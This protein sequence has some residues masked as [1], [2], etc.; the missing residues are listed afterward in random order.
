[1]AQRGLV[2]CPRPHSPSLAEL[3]FGSSFILSILNNEEL[4]SGQQ[5]QR[6]DT[7]HELAEEMAGPR[8]C[9]GTGWPGLRSNSSRNVMNHRAQATSSLAVVVTD[10]F[11]LHPV[12]EV[13]GLGIGPCSRASGNPALSPDLLGSSTLLGLRLWS[14][15]HVAFCKLS[16]WTSLVP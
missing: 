1:M 9:S 13:K 7:E 12:P 15:K 14:C 11:T 8:R 3:R 6:C 10:S 5:T 4:P 2:T 16:E